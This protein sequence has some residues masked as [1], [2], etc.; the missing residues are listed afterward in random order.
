MNTYLYRCIS[1]KVSLVNDPFNDKL[2]P[3]IK[4]NQKTF[5]GFTSTSHNPKATINFLGTKQ[6]LKTGK[7]HKIQ[8]KCPPRDNHCYHFDIFSSRHFSY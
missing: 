7:I 3:Y 6:Q 4:G 5:W 2:I 1:H 8:I